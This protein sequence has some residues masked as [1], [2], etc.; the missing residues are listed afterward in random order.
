LVFHGKKTVPASLRRD[1]WSPYFSMHLPSSHTGLLAYHQLRELSLQRQ[2]SPP[3]SLSMTTIERA[4]KAMRAKMSKEQEETWD[5][6]R[7]G[8]PYRD[9]L[10]RLKFRRERAKALM[11]QKATSVADVA[12]VIELLQREGH[13]LSPS[14]GEERVEARRAR[15]LQMAG[16]RRRKKLRKLWTGLEGRKKKHEEKRM[17]VQEGTKWGLEKYA[18]KRI[19]LE[20]GGVVVDPYLGRTKVLL[21]GNADKEEEPEALYLKLDEV[22]GAGEEVE[23][24]DKSSA[25]TANVS[26]K[27]AQSDSASDTSTV[28]SEKEEQPTSEPPDT[29]AATPKTPSSPAFPV[30]IF[31]SDLRDAAYAA[32]W[33][34]IVLHGELERMAVSRSATRDREG[35]VG[36]PHF[37]DR[38]VHVIGVGKIAGDAG[39]DAWMRGGYSQGGTFAKEKEV[40]MDSGK[41]VERDNG[42]GLK[43]GDK[44]GEPGVG[45]D[46][47]PDASKSREEQTEQLERDGVVVEPP[48]QNRGLWGWAKRRLGLAS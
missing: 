30:R 43:G 22:A 19:A 39:G 25:T 15:R 4:S 27:A 23:L 46:L 1:L 21:P 35:N 47:D 32:K 31:W 37:R 17:Q 14:A 29:T 40:V 2:L 20:H 41:R 48:P 18:A 12:F 6:E 10:P 33:P 34:Q 11:Q 45:S 36:V 5:E 13:M 38:S 9:G 24:T 16:K 3:D 42:D 8:Q 44:D 7:E 28:I 26:G